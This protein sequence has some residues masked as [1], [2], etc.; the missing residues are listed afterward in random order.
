M[1]ASVG[2]AL[3]RREVIEVQRRSLYHLLH[4]HGQDRV[5]IVKDLSKAVLDSGGSVVESRALRMGGDFAVM[6]R[7]QGDKAP[8]VQ[9]DGLDIEIKE[10]S[11]EIFERTPGAVHAADFDVQGPD[12]PGIVYAISNYI[13]SKGLRIE[14]MHTEK[15]AAPFGGT[16]LFCM[17]GSVLSTEP[18]DIAVLSADAV[19]VCYCSLPRARHTASNRESCLASI[20]I[21]YA[22]LTY[23]EPNTS[24]LSVS[25]SRWRMILAL[26]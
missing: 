5:G 6:M 15:R 24:S 10:T 16:D 3:G 7:I 26:M 8:S 21:V 12:V 18:I 1:L 22:S 23:P 19:G 13:S 2:R 11:Q 4:A 20:S 17:S 14:Q 9:L 25:L